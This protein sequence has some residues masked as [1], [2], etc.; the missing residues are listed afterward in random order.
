MRHVS[1]RGSFGLADRFSGADNEQVG[2]HADRGPFRLVLVADLR[3]YAAG[4][5]TQLRRVLP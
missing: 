2:D 5:R 1:P 4:P 3:D